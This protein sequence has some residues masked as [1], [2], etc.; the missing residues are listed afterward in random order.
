MK[1]VNNYDDYKLLRPWDIRAEEQHLVLIDEKDEE[2]HISWSEIKRALTIGGEEENKTFIF[3][4][5]EGEKFSIELNY[6]YYENYE[7]LR[8]EIR[9]HIGH[10]EWEWFWFPKVREEEDDVLGK[11]IKRY[12]IPIIIFLGVMM[13][14]LWMLI[15]V[16]KGLSDLR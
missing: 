14:G 7:I 4:E 9:K 3:V 1:E 11:Y 2:E 6:Y 10:I 13:L 15:N 8:E 5:R 16:M 12:L